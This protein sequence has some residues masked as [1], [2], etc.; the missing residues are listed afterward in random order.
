MHLSTLVTITLMVGLFIGANLADYRQTCCW[1][2]G[3]I[4]SCII[5]FPEVI[6]YRHALSDE[7]PKTGVWD[8]EAICFDVVVDAFAIW[9]VVIWIASIRESSF[10]KLSKVSIGAGVVVMIG[11]IGINGC[12]KE[13]IVKLGGEIEQNQITLAQAQELDKVE[14]TSEN[15]PRIHRTRAYGWPAQIGSIDEIV[16]PGPNGWRNDDDYGPS[17]GFQWTT[18]YGDRFWGL[19]YLFV[20]GVVMTMILMLVARVARWCKV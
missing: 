12:P 2:D 10:R 20:D 13:R 9:V 11:G 19:R 1:K 17:I 14:P 16:R 3:E 5:G 15:R 6:Y 18:R 7:G 8:P 4:D